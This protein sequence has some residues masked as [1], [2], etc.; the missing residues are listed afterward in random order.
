MKLSDLISKKLKP[1]NRGIY[2]IKGGQFLG[3]TFVYIDTADNYYNFLSLPDNLIR[4]VPIN[5]FEFALKH[6]II[7]LIERLP[8]SHWKVCKAQY[9]KNFN[10]RRE[11]PD[12][13]K[14]LDSQN[15]SGEE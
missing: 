1:K 12:L 14:L 5:S 10:T 7:E 9:E 11:Q 6:D 8:S 3:E 2:A 15:E 4:N 13:S